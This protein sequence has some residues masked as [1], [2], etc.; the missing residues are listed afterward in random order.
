MNVCWV[1]THNFNPTELL[2]P[3]RLKETGPVWGP[4]SIWSK[5]WQ[6]NVITDDFDV[7]RQL[8]RNN[9]NQNCNLWF[10]DNFYVKL[11]R[12]I[13]INVFNWNVSVEVPN[14]EDVL[15]LQLASN[16]YDIILCLGW[17][18]HSLAGYD[19]GIEKHLRQNYLNYITAIVKQAKSQFVFVDPQGIDIHPGLTQQE[20]FSTDTA[21][22]TLELLKQL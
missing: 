5:L 8:L 10:N 7:A 21:E 3:D 11:G 9:F 1:A 12:P 15:S 18:L 14:R 16:R 6:D 4:Y 2:T 13:N 20:N 22:N 17:D 19:A